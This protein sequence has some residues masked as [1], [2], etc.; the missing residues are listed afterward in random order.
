MR[1]YKEFLGAFA[2][3][4]LPNSRKGTH[5]VI[6]NTDP[7]TKPGTH[8]VAIHAENGSAEYFDPFGLPPFVPSIQKH[9]LSQYRKVV[10]CTA[11]LQAFVSIKCG[12]FCIEYL[13]AKFEGVETADFIWQF[14]NER[15]FNDVILDYI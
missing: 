13:K 15:P 6:I 1:S 14:S 10:Y 11:P 12:E 4:Q 9:L 2:S 7:H 5:G 8:W 3:D